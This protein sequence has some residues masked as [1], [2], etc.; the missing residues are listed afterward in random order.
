MP[1]TPEDIRTKEFR[2]SIRGYNE[3]EVDAF[4]PQDVLDVVQKLA[5]RVAR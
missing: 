3:H 5:G 1:L 4:G 2:N